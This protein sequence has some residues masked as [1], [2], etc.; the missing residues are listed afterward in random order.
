LSEK[1]TP[2]AAQLFIQENLTSYPNDR[3]RYDEIDTETFAKLKRE[4]ENAVKARGSIGYN[5]TM[6]AK[7]YADRNKRILGI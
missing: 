6:I 7:R 4:G 5:K 1:V 3:K 2:V